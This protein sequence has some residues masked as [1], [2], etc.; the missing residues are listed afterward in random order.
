MRYNGLMTNELLVEC[1]NCGDEVPESEADGVL[2]S[3]GGWH[4][5]DEYATVCLPCEA[6]AEARADAMADRDW[7]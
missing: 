4:E 1:E 2:V 3:R 6:A 5:P 7:D